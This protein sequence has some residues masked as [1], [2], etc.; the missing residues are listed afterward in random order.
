YGATINLETTLSASGSITGDFSAIDSNFNS[1][2]V[3]VSSG[4]ATSNGTVFTISYPISLTDTV[5]GSGEVV[6]HAQ[7]D[8]ALGTIQLP[9]L[10]PSRASISRCPQW[11]MDLVPSLPHHKVSIAPRLAQLLIPRARRFL[12]QLQRAQPPLFQDGA[13]PALE[14]PRRH[15]SLWMPTRVAP[16][17]KRSPRHLLFL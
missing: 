6:I 14:L 7:T 2:N 17:P 5:R 1:K 8:T 15:R 4:N 9:S 11:E 12:S 10:P 16:L 13:A 3:V